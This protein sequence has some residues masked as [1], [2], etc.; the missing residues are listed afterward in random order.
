MCREDQCWSCARCGAVW[1][2]Q[3]EACACFELAPPDVVDENPGPDVGEG[4]RVCAICGV[5]LAR[6][7]VGDDLV[8]D[9]CERCGGILL[10][11]GESLKL[12]GKLASGRDGPRFRR[13]L[14]SFVLGV[15]GARGPYR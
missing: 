2:S 4:L 10:D 11:A 6:V 13:L 5:P 1:F 7:K 3:E 12:R 14:S 15:P 9:L 8:L